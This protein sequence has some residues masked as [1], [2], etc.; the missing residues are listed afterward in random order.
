MPDNYW[1]WCGVVVGAFAGAI[2]VV[3]A[4]VYLGVH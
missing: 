1:F 4:L 3:A 2:L